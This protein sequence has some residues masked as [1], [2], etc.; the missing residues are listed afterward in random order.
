MIAVLL[1][2]FLHVGCLRAFRSLDDFK[3]DCISFLQGA[4]AIARDCGIVYE[5][6]RAIFAPDKAV[7]F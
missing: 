3:F 6:I 7:A 4:V 5:N 1:A 2:W